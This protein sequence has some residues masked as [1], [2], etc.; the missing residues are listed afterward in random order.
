MEE[1]EQLLGGRPL[2]L[3]TP[4]SVSAC[5]GPAAEGPEALGGGDGGSGSEAEGQTG[6]FHR[7]HSGRLTDLMFVKLRVSTRLLSTLTSSQLFDRS[8]KPNPTLSFI[9]SKY[10]GLF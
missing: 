6:E 10:F 2:P 3:F 8:Q 4:E 1:E 7:I 9:F 5:A